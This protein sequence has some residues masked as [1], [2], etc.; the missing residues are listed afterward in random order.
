[1]NVSIRV[2]EHF[3]HT[4]NE[5]SIILKFTFEK[6]QTTRRISII[7]EAFHRCHESLCMTWSVLR[8]TMH[9]ARYTSTAPWIMHGVAFNLLDTE[10]HNAFHFPFCLGSCAGVIMFIHCEYAIYTFS[11]SI[12]RQALRVIPRGKHRLTVYRAPQ[13]VPT[14]INDF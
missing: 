3:L 11:I 6:Y 5:M 4:S 12:R 8:R 9:G 10:I 7:I 13:V 2:T 1:M 14:A